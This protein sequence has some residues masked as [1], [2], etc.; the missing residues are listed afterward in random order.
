MH[1]GVLPPIGPTGEYAQVIDC[2]QP[3]KRK[4]AD[5]LKIQVKN[6]P[7]TRRAAHL[8]K[9]HMQRLSIPQR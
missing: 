2:L 7:G 3:S 6:H 5:L 8:D 4:L 1:V 9:T